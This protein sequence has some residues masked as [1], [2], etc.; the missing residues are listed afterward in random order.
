MKCLKVSF[1]VLVVTFLLSACTNP[2]VVIKQNVEWTSD[3]DLLT[4]TIEGEEQY[5]G[6]GTLK[7]DDTLIPVKIFIAIPAY[8]IYVFDEPTY[9]QWQDTGNTSVA[10]IM[11]GFKRLNTQGTS[12]EII[13]TVN[14]SSYPELDNL[15]FMMTRTDLKS[16]Q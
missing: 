6:E 15:K 7:I 13:S 10:L 9:L 16:K 3:N 5:N 2:M 1:L 8:E 14:Q 4:F 12:I 11:F